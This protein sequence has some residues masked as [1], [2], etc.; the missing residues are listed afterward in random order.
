M[1]PVAVNP[2]IT[3]TQLV[4]EI[5]TVEDTNTVIDQ[6]IAKLRRRINASKNTLSE[7]IRKPTQPSEELRAVEAGATYQSNNDDIQRRLEISA[8][9]PFEE[10]VNKR[11]PIFTITIK[12]MV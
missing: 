1:K 3:F 5:T 9:M 4:E 11:A 10:L 7:R 6:L 8:G 2:N 12:R